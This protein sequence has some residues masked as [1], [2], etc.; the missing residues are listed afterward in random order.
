MKTAQQTWF[1]SLLAKAYRGLLGFVCLFVSKRFFFYVTQADPDTWSPCISILSVSVWVI[2]MCYYSWF[3]SLLLRSQV[4]YIPRE[5]GRNDVSRNPQC[6]AGDS[7]KPVTAVEGSGHIF[8]T[9]C[10][11]LSAF[12]VCPKN[13]N[14]HN[15]SIG[16]WIASPSG[17]HFTQVCIHRTLSWC[18]AQT[19]NPVSICWPDTPPPK[20]KLTF[21]EKS[22]NGYPEWLRESTSGFLT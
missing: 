20:K 14:I 19:R 13:S 18:L 9:M 22:W 12:M 11:P 6:P 8:P 21:V 17:R 2:N 7:E 16:S 1:Y 5:N 10:P 4:F 3:A 15:D